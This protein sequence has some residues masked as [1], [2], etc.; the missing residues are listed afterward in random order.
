MGRAAQTPDGVASTGDHA[1]GYLL[2]MA[3]SMRARRPVPEAWNPP[4][5]APERTGSSSL[6]G[7][8][9]E[10][11]L[12]FPP[13]APTAPRGGGRP[14]PTPSGADVAA[15]LRPSSP[16]DCPRRASV[17][18][19]LAALRF[20]G[21]ARRAR[22][23][24][25][26]AGCSAPGASGGPRRAAGVWTQRRKPPRARE[27]ASRGPWRAQRAAEGGAWPPTVARPR[28]AAGRSGRGAVGGGGAGG[29]RRFT[30][31]RLSLVTQNE[32]KAHRTQNAPLPPQLRAL[33]RRVE[34]RA[35]VLERAARAQA[36]NDVPPAACAAPPPL[37]R[38]T[39]ALSRAWPRPA[40]PGNTVGQSG[41]AQ[42]RR[43]MIAH[44]PAQQPIWPPPPRPRQRERR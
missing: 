33:D 5:A 30:S 25:T 26:G 12:P 11:V 43:A 19:H 29:A 1:R 37:R 38:P 18:G 4:H 28:K 41:S 6:L 8:D 27:P 44:L 15:A 39:A 32:Q 34:S 35:L 42:G 10:R 17:R 21:A 7:P 40:H 14:C 16:E 36:P 22:D 31:P 3:P 23:G 20:R 2:D 24:G 13:H 9:A